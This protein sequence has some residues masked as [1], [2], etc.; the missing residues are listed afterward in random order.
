[1]AYKSYFTRLI[2]KSLGKH[3]HRMIKYLLQTCKENLLT[4]HQDYSDYSLVST[5][6]HPGMPVKGN[7]NRIG[8]KITEKML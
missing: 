1:M 8:K 5:K 3:Q 7:E 6:I 2:T 4:I